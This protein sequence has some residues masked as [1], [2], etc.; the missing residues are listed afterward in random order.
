MHGG[1]EDDVY[2][3]I[4]ACMGHEWRRKFT[5]DRHYN[6]AKRDNDAREYVE[7]WNGQWFAKLSRHW[8]EKS[9]NHGEEAAR[10]INAE[11]ETSVSER[12]KSTVRDDLRE[13]FEE[14]MGKASIE[15]IR[16]LRDVL[17]G[18]ESSRGPDETIAIAEAFSW[19]IGRHTDYIRVPYKHQKLVE[20]YLEL[21]EKCDD[22]RSAA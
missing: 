21:L 19:E 7:K 5:E 17:M 4:W 3:L 13:R 9:L 1:H 11:L 18:S 14:F 16:L 20:Q 22:K 12:V 10:V 2:G 6:A 8:P 15:E